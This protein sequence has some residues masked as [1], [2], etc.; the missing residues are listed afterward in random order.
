MFTLWFLFGWEGGRKERR[1]AQM[2]KTRVFLSLKTVNW[3]K[4]GGIPLQIW[5]FGWKVV[6][7]W[8]AR[9]GLWCVHC[10][11]HHAL[12]CEKK[13]WTFQTPGSCKLYPYWGQRGVAHVRVEAPLP[14]STSPL[15]SPPSLSQ[16]AAFYVFGQP[17]FLYFTWLSSN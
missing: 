10:R 2:Y 5:V 15:S 4:T 13:E 11:A 6:C 16:E 3:G 14:P 17:V 12:I 1:K 8:E 7:L 9:R